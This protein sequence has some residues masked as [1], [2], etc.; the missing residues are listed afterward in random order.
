MYKNYSSTI[1]QSKMVPLLSQEKANAPTSFMQNDEYG[2]I[3]RLFLHAD[4]EN[5]VLGVSLEK[6]FTIT[7]KVCLAPSLRELACEARLREF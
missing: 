7:H 1:L 6:I 3:N 4:A 5:I 2:F